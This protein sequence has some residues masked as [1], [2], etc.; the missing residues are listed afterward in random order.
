MG[1]SNP[2]MAIMNFELKVFKLNSKDFK[3]GNSA[4]QNLAKGLDLPI[5]T[6]L[7]H[8]IPMLIEK[9]E[10]SFPMDEQWVSSWLF[11]PNDTIESAGWRG[12]I[13]RNYSPFLHTHPKVS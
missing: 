7:L 8:L 3:G 1:R 10:K 2:F 9:K 6:Q 4:A 5:I 11:L 12:E 13:Q